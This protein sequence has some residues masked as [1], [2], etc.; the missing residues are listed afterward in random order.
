MVG[1]VVKVVGE[2]VEFGHMLVNVLQKKQSSQRNLHVA[3]FAISVTNELVCFFIV[4]GVK[5]S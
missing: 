5:C 4:F 1:E 3:L 2:T